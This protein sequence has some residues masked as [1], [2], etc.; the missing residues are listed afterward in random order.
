MRPQRLGEEPQLRRHLGL[1]AEHVERVAPR[2]DDPV[3]GNPNVGRRT[4]LDVDLYEVFEYV[5]PGV[6]TQRAHGS[7]FVRAQGSDF[8]DPRRE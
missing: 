3:A 4:A 7:I 6:Q 2:G 1:G 8:L 5:A